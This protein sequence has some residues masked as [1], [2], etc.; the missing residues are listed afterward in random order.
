MLECAAQ[1][2]QGG[3]KMA[4]TFEGGYGVYRVPLG[5]EGSFIEIKTELAGLMRCGCLELRR[6]ALLRLLALVA[7]SAGDTNV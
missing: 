4:E 2:N 6:G 7:T 3:S 5:I 1:E